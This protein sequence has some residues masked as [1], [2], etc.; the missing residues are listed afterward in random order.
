VLAD[1]EPVFNGKHC[2]R[3]RVENNTDFVVYAISHPVV[4]YADGSCADKRGYILM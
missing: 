4:K 2:W 3:I 1:C